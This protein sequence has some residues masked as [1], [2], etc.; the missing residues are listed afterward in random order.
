MQEWG[1]PIPVEVSVCQAGAAL[2]HLPG[3][4]LELVKLVCAM[5]G[6]VFVSTCMTFTINSTVT[7][8][9]LLIY[10]HLL[11]GNTVYRI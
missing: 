8:C 9:L 3:K 5:A 2:L 6:S 7:F 4:I 11:Y 10:L 1:Q